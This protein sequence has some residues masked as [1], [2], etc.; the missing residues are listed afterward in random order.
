MRTLT[1]IV[2]IGF[3]AAAQGPQHPLDGLTT[4]EFWTVYETLEQAGHAPEGTLFA[5][6]LL[7][8][9][10]KAA[11]LAWQPGRPMPR[12]ADVVLLREGK[13]Y[14]A[15]VDVAGKRVVQHAELQGAQAPFLGSELGGGDEILKKD[16]QVV[17]ALAKRGIKDLRTVQCVALPVAWRSVPEQATKRIGFGSCAVTRR[18][19][20]GWGRSIEGLMILVDM[21]EKK[22][23]R[24]EDRGVSPV[25]SGDIN[26]E[27]LPENPRPHTT[28]LATAQPMGPGYRMEK[29]EVQWQ[30]WRFR[31]RLDQ[32]VG[33]VVNLVRYVDKGRARSVMYEGHVSELFVPYMDTTIGW[34]NRAFIDAGQFF[35]AGGFLKAMRPGLDCPAHADWFDMVTAG[36]NG[37][38]KLA[39]N[40][41]CLFERNPEGPAWRHAEGGEVFG[42][43]T[44]QLV[45]RASAAIGNYD[46]I[47][48]WRFDP[49]G[50]IEVA[51]GAT[52]VIET[53]ATAQKNAAHG[54]HAGPEMGQFVDANT[55]G[56]N[57]DHY[58]S[59]RLDLDVDGP[60]NS[61]MIHRLVR[62]A[63]END[64]MR[65]S[66]WVAEAST[67]ARE[68][69]AILDKRI[70]QP[71]MW[72]FVNPS[73]KGA[74]GYPR[75]YEVMAGATAKSLMAAEDPAQRLGA[76]SE[77]QFWVTPQDPGQRYAAGT[78]P[79]SSDGKDGLAVW[80]QAN[81]PIANTD[82]VG[83]YTLGF[84][85]VPRAEDW[86]V[87]PAM[88]HSFQ[89]R[90]FHFFDRNPVLDLPKSLAA[91][92]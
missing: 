61:F 15:Q 28:P 84:H 88:W 83:W 60:Q 44:R 16:P 81:R 67:A 24:V 10:A 30:N 22:V 26:Y 54:G 73:E 68:K 4:A 31:F 14:T 79:T 91:K 58:F 6:V 86:P 39:S 37:A 48:D 89:I 62:K 5:S 77:H 76:F 50:T 51:V 65:K 55:I 49:D 59:Y 78:Y 20:H 85:H 52:G 56:V 47:L 3:T 2:W 8:P 87:M 66:I 92:P 63:V 13:S 29:G 57:H 7:G 21:V 41:A 27:E 35:A 45:L 23:I 36:E 9:P 70:E 38:P 17:A 64:P 33:P 82:I 19:Y 43:P 42:R 69:D 32:R 53:K 75:G 12:E 34:N 71:A 72:M 1:L 46:Y 18:V 40:M 90:P 74:M 25:P 80:T 11:A